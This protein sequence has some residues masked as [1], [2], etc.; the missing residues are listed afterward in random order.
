M[1]GTLTTFPAA[2]ATDAYRFVVGSCSFINDTTGFKV[3]DCIR[4]LSPVPAFYLHIGD[5][6]YDDNVDG[7]DPA[8]LAALAADPLAMKRNPRYYVRGFKKWP[9]VQSLNDLVPGF[10]MVDDHD[11]VFNDYEW[12]TAIAGSSYSTI[13]IA[14]RTAWLE[15]APHPTQFDTNGEVLGYQFDLGASRFIVGDYRSLRRYTN[16]AIPTLLGNS[17]GPGTFDQYTAVANAIAQAAT[18]GIKMLHFVVDCTWASGN[19]GY[20]FAAITAAAAG[21][22]AANSQKERHRPLRC[23]PRRRTGLPVAALRHPCRRHAPV[24]RRRRRDHLD[25]LLHPRHPARRAVRLLGLAEH[26]A[27]HRDLHLE[28]RQRE[29]QPIRQHAGG[30][31]RRGRPPADHG[32]LLRLRDGFGGSGRAVQDRRPGQLG[33]T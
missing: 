25:G 20:G 12:N 5:L 19:D 24:L 4:A 11:F 29:A 30:L 21:V 6:T 26:G 10:L 33:L 15:T 8:F 17:S 23:D 1:T 27:E 18:D 2:G 28:R 14:A 7:D 31:R 9:E 3:P 16:G 22:S 32:H 13:G